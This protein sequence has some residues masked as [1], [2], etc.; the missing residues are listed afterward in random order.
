MRLSFLKWIA[1]AA[2][3]TVQPASAQVEVFV[4]DFGGWLTANA[5]AT[6]LIDFETLPGGSPSQ[7]G[8]P[9]T[10]DFNYTDQGVTFMPPFPVD[11]FGIAGSPASGFDLR[12]WMNNPFERAWIV[13]DLVVPSP[14]VGVFFPGGTTFSAFDSAGNLI[15]S[16]FFGAPGGPHFIGFVS[17]IPI[18]RVTADD[19]S[20]TET[21]DAFVFNPTPEPTSA[22]LFG[23][24]ALVGLLK[25][26]RRRL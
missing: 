4:E 3:F 17:D 24:A 13:A 21:I 16:Q 18:A 15:A 6:T 12:T 25:R 26:P 14:A 2:L 20:F 23:A 9:I 10:P 22:L 1:L 5:G 19:G 11:F 8:I 7:A